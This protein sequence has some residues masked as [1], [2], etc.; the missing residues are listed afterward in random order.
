MNFFFSGFSK[1]LFS[2]HL[3]QCHERHQITPASSFHSLLLNQVFT[4]K[5]LSLVCIFSL[6]ACVWSLTGL[7][8]LKQALHCSPYCTLWTGST[9]ASV[10]ESGARGE[11]PADPPVHNNARPCSMAPGPVSPTVPAPL[12]P[13]ILW[14]LRRS[15]GCHGS[16]G[17][18]KMNL[19]S[20]LPP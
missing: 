5:R 1:I 7:A 6:A 4:G 14:A 20:R 16:L 13:H 10:A 3:N 11:T 9:D 17:A 19:H 8:D 15:V 12:T 18:L 2:T